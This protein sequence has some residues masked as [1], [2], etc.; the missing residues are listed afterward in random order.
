[1]EVKQRLQEGQA[2]PV[3]WIRLFH[4]NNELH[5]GQRLID[6]VHSKARRSGGSGK[7]SSSRIRLRISR[8]VPRRST[9]PPSRTTSRSKASGRTSML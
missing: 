2:V 5:N 1:M 3:A 6:L 8:F 4:G 9:Q 7:A